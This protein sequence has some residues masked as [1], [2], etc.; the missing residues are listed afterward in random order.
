MITLTGTQ[1]STVEIDPKD[2]GQYYLDANGDFG[3]GGKIK[4]SV[5]FD[6]GTTYSFLTTAVGVDLEITADYNAT[7]TLPGDVVVKFEA[8]N[9]ITSVKIHLAKV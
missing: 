9:S 8:V 5:S 4:A 1:N 7:I 6:G 2:G 3:S